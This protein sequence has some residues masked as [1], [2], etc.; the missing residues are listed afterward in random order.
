MRSTAAGRKPAEAPRGADGTRAAGRFKRPISINTRIQIYLDRASAPQ[1]AARSD[2][3]CAGTP[4]PRIRQVV[5]ILF[6]DAPPPEQYPDSDRRAG[7]GQMTAGRRRVGAPICA[8]KR[9]AALWLQKRHAAQTRKKEEKKKNKKWIWRFCRAGAGVK[10]EFENRPARA[11]IEEVKASP[12]PIRH[13][14]S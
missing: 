6:P 12:T 13:C 7:V 3:R 11:C 5:D 10:G 9:L 2:P 1:N 14:S 4:I 8:S